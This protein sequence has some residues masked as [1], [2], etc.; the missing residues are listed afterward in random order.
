MCSNSKQIFH[1]FVTRRYFSMANTMF[2]L[3]S[4]LFCFS[5][6]YSLNQIESTRLKL[7]QP[8][9]K[10][11]FY[12][13]ASH[14]S[15]STLQANQTDQQLTPDS[16]YFLSPFEQI[17][18]VHPTT[19]IALISVQDYRTDTGAWLNSLEHIY[20]N[21]MK[22]F[23]DIRF[24]LI[25][26]KDYYNPAWVNRVRKN[27][28]FE[29]YQELD[30]S[31][32][33][34]LLDGASGDVF[35]FDRCNL[36]AYYIRFPLSFI[37][38][39][40]PF[41][42]ATIIAAHTDSPC[43][44]KCG[45]KLS[46]DSI[47]INST[48]RVEITTQSSIETITSSLN[49]IEQKNETESDPN[50]TNDSLT[51]V[52]SQM[53]EVLQSFYDRY[54]ANFVS[55]ESNETIDDHNVTHKTSSNASDLL[56]TL[57][58]TLEYFAENATNQ[59]TKQQPNGTFQQKALL[60]NGQQVSESCNRTICSEWTTEKLLAARLC[61]LSFHNDDEDEDPINDSM[62]NVNASHYIPSNGGFGCS[63]YP[64]TTCSMIKPVLQCCTRK[65]FNEYFNYAVKLRARQSKLNYGQRSIQSDSKSSDT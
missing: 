24:L 47:E 6:F 62:L 55:E 11:R 15:N 58:R 59:T 53:G 51:N 19:V 23:K 7:C 12:D 34:S 36:L 33:G 10:W 48:A 20:R 61:C 5:L 38:Q 21:L 65:L 17:D 27:V 63:L 50:E 31:P 54:T 9:P 37:D 25:N 13:I 2:K 42:Q 43:E 56:V 29:V 44:G 46:N 35:I 28:S 39:K 3:F 49:E 14:S 41:F 16:R 30:S 60:S 1:F 18:D 64:R 52:L 4:L 8:P 26:S 57:N 32:I 45:Q 22:S 40:D